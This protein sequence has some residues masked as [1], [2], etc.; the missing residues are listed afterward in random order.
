MAKKI[1]TEAGSKVQRFVNRGY[2]PGLAAIRAS[3]GMCLLAVLACGPAFAA[4]TYRVKVGEYP[5]FTALS[6][7]GRM[8][9]VTSFGSG[10]VLAVDIGSRTVTQSIEVGGAP[11]G[12]ALTGDG[13]YALVACRDSGTVVVLDLVSF[14]IEATIKVGGAPTRSRWALEDIEPLSQDGGAAARGLFTLS[15]SGI[16]R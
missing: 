14:R 5:N 13:R 7:D 1:Q 10:E 15:T 3:A 6:P 4:R 2:R 9:Y 11:L 12:T 16:G 8:A